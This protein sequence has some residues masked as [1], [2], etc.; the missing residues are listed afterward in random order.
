MNIDLMQVAYSFLSVFIVMNVGLILTSLVPQIS[1][2]VDR[3]VG[4]RLFQSY[5]DLIKVYV[6]RDIFNHGIMFYLGPVFRLTSGVGMVVFMPM[7]VGSEIFS[8]MSFAGDI[9]LVSYFMFFGTLGMALGAGEAGH[10][11]SAIGIAR[12]LAQL[13]AAEIPLILANLSLAIQ[14]NTLSITEIMNAQQG[15]ILNWTAFTNPIATIAVIFA[16]LGSM[17]RS[18]FNVVV[19]PQEIP[20][21]PPTEY[22]SS[23]MGVMATNRTI[24]SVA[25]AIL[26][27]NLYFGG[28]SNWPLLILKAF[29]LYMVSVIV[30]HVFPRF[31]VDQSIKWFM[32]L[33][34]VL[35]IL[36]VIFV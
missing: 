9:V 20:I 29:M 34:F 21:G 31:R 1:A 27:V 8:N 24:Y 3:R 7:L 11:Y 16:W 6:Q 13:T 10:P 14:Y 26:F 18:P 36:A 32:K 35:G 22:H 33:P 15:G 23:L 30:G 28:A 4:R 12:G 5:Y 25:K 17:G 19:A 2:R